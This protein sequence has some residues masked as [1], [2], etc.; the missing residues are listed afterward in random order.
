MASSTRPKRS[1]ASQPKA[2][3]LEI[4]RHIPGWPSK[5]RLDPAPLLAALQVMPM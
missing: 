5:R 3:A 2:V 4:T 1:A